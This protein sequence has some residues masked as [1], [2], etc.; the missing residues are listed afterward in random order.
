M[1][2]SV[3]EDTFGPDPLS[4]AALRL[5]PKVGTVMAQFREDRYE[6]QKRRAEMLGEAAAELLDPESLFEKIAKDERLADMFE[7]AVAAA[8]ASGS[9][10]KIRLLGR[11]LASGAL[12]TDVAKVDAMQEVLRVAKELE[13]IDIRALLHFGGETS[14]RTPDADLEAGLGCE[15]AV[16]RIVVARLERLG[17]FGSESSGW[18]SFPDDK[19]DHSVE[20]DDEW[21]VTVAGESV[22][23]VLKNKALD[24]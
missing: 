8:V 22:L 2:P 23:S 11:A 13:S 6:Q 14:T 9:E 1:E 3:V 5:I 12:A 7:D 16:A 4:Q 10:D 24:H 21:I 20:V 15:P 17:L 18:V 19:D